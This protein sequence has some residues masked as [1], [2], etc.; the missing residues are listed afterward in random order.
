[1]MMVVVV[2]MMMRVVILATTTNTLRGARR[3]GSGRCRSSI[4]TLAYI[5]QQSNEILKAEQETIGWGTGTERGV[6]KVN[7]TH[8]G[9]CVDLRA[10]PMA[11][12]TCAVEYLGQITRFDRRNRWWCRICRWAT[13]TTIGDLESWYHWHCQEGVIR[14]LVTYHSF[15][16]CRVLGLRSLTIVQAIDFVI[17]VD[18]DTSDNFLVV[19]VIETI[20]ISRCKVIIVVVFKFVLIFFAVTVR[21]FWG[22]MPAMMWGRAP[23][24]HHQ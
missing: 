8:V 14:W 20:L 18:R 7:H 1:M 13:N 19:I 16:G 22:R 4:A 11:M 24:G 10:W 21:L 5:T 2:Q 9:A 12:I 3:C 15:I 17:K 23:F 6:S